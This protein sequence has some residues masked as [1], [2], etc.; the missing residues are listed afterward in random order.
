MGW[1]K[2]KDK[3]PE[4][5]APL[6]DEPLQNSHPCPGLTE[7]DDK[8]VPV[9]LRRTGFPGGGARSV[10]EIAKDLFKRLFSKLGAVKKKR[11]IDIQL[12]EHQWRNDHERSRVFST[13]CKH[14]VADPAPNV[15]ALP[16][17]PCGDLLRNQRF[18]AVI[19]KPI[20]EDKNYIYTNY[21][22]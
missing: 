16:C 17:Q 19:R 2:V 9:Y 10:A 14:L 22:Y 18:K 3:A 11:V 21:R 6:L 4:S 1:A 8:W 13:E 7:L 12:H 15:R 20:P 5:P